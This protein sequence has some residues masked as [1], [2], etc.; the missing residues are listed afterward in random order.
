MDS[1]MKII[2]DVA[3]ELSGFRPFP[4]DDFSFLD[5]LEYTELVMEVEK[6]CDKRIPDG[7]FPETVEK[8]AEMLEKI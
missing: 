8:L 4:E 1:I 6:R 2:Q 5:S 7:V 3:E